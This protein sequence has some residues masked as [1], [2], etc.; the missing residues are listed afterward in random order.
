[1]GVTF[2]GTPL[3]HFRFYSLHNIINITFV[4]NVQKMRYRVG[5]ACEIADTGI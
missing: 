1:M 4:H 2:S 3:P 5:I